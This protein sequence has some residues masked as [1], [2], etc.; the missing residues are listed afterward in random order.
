[1]RTAPTP[2]AFY[3][4]RRD[5]WEADRW[6]AWCNSTQ[7][8]TNITESSQTGPAPTPNQQACHTDNRTRR[9]HQ[10]HGHLASGSAQLSVPVPATRRPERRDHT[11]GPTP[12]PTP[13]LT[14][15]PASRKGMRAHT[16]GVST[17]LGHLASGSAQLS[18]PAPA[19]HRSDRRDHTN[20]PTPTPTPTSNPAMSARTTPTPHRDRESNDLLAS[21]VNTLSVAA[22][23]TAAAAATTDKLKTA[24]VVAAIADTLADYQAVRPPPEIRRRGGRPPRKNPSSLRAHRQ[25]RPS[26]AEAVP[27]TESPPHRRGGWRPPRRARGWIAPQSGDGQ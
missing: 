13:T 21:L 5:W 9:E 27:L 24:A 3:P 25:P 17:S 26:D 19:T 4:E 12:T 20:G 14:S 10:L 15:N 8:G 22:A 11:N 18:A 16:P 23:A 7:W 6:A 2:M 1:M